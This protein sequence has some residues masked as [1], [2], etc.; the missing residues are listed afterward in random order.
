M[1]IN[2]RIT[3]FRGQYRFLSNFFP[4]PIEYQGKIWPT[5]EH[6]YQAARTPDRGQ[7]EKIRLARTPSIAKRLGRRVDL[8]PDWNEIRVGIM[9]DLI[10]LK[11]THPHLRKRLMET[12]T[13]D[14]IEGNT[15]HDNFWGV[16]QCGKCC[17]RE[18]LNI[19]GTILMQQ[20]IVSHA[21]GEA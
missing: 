19:L 16:C 7:R 11:F 21:L 14:L 9:C 17:Q 3:S 20:R 4:S 8:R 6:A 13:A 12:G 1:G 15:W 10:K 18:G 2:D 5:V